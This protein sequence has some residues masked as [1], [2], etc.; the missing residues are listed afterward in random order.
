VL[1][2]G[3]GGFG[4]CKK[5]EDGSFGF[6]QGS[7]LLN[8]VIPVTP[9]SDLWDLEFLPGMQRGSLLYI[10]RLVTP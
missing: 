3:T 8:C 5:L 1:S 7:H 6:V 9:R 10:L 4:C 2:V